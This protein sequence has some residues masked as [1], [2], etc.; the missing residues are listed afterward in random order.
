MIEYSLKIV[1]HTNIDIVFYATSSCSIK[2][3]KSANIKPGKK[4]VTTG[5]NID[6][7]KDAVIVLFF[8]I[9]FINLTKNNFNTQLTY[10]YMF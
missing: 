3:K 7:R 6:G 5:V 4:S 2:T 8:L 1:F 10:N 9:Y